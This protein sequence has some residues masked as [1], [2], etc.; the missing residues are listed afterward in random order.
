MN[1]ILLTNNNSKYGKQMLMEFSQASVPLAA[2]VVI[3]QPISYHFK[4]FFYVKSKIGLLQAIYFSI[5]LGFESFTSKSNYIK[6]SNYS[7]NVIYTTG[8]NTK[9]TETILNEL[10]TDIL[11]LAQ[12]GII[13]DN[14][15]KTARIGVLNGHPGL[16]P[17]YRGID[18]H[19]WAIMKNEQSKIGS[20]IHWVNVGV[21]TGNIIKTTKYKINHGE[22]LSELEWN[23]YLQ[24][25]FDFVEIINNLLDG[26]TITGIPQSKKDGKQYYKMPI[27]LER[28][29]KVIMRYLK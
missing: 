16:L 8:T 22:S 10:K 5:K 15:I 25:I 1:I 18:C 19:K 2:V 7:N 20:S 17:H 24:C 29:V 12:T 23:L 28:K 26:R 14:I 27:Q 3:N 4:L 13:R 21:D 9:K 11:I 6:Y